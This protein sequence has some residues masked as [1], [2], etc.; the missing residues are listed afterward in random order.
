MPPEQFIRLLDAVPRLKIRKWKD[1][2]VVMLFKITYW[3]A[4]RIGEA[5][6]LQVDDFDLELRYV[7]LGRT[8]TE[9]NDKRIIPVAFVPELRQYLKDK[10]GALFPGMN[11]PIVYNWLIR[12]GKMLDIKALTT[13]QSE[14][15]EKTK[16]HIFRKSRGKDMYFGALTGHKADIMHV[17]DR[18][19]HKGKNRLASTVMYL[20]LGEEGVRNYDDEEARILN[21]DKND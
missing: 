12:L 1:S 5:L 19:G 11:Y 13:P 14:T 10:H 20:Q 8:K 7:Y 9:V 6:K 15:R 17:S 4:L 16:T 2:D 18:L 3:I 21:D